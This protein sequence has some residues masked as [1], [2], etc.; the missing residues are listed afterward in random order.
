VN[1]ALVFEGGGSKGG[2]AVRMALRLVAAGRTYQVLSGE[3]IGAVNAYLAGVLGFSELAG[4]WPKIEAR[5]IYRGG[6][7]AEKAATIV[8]WRSGFYDMSPCYDT[9]RRAIR[10]PKTGGLR[11]IRPGVTVVVT[12]TDLATGA[13]LEHRLDENTPPDS[14]IQCVMD[15]CLVPMAHGARDNR[16]ADGGVS[17]SA[18]LGPVVRAGAEHADVILLDRLGV[19]PWQPSP[20]ATHQAARAIELLREGVFWRDVDATV[21]RNRLAV[22]GDA[23]YKRIEATFYDPQGKLHD[24][25]DWSAKRVPLWSAMTWGSRPLAEAHTYMKGLR[26]EA[27]LASLA[28]GIPVR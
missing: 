15:S 2:Y 19:D 18:P 7:G 1:R 28:S 4:L 8:G 20:K 12:V 14:C 3:S 25:M 23:G 10:D 6:G 17:A 27:Q 11:R 21:T 16:W 13:M 5:D 22:L 24:W 9:L 26:L